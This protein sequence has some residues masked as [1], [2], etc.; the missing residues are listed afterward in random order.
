MLQLEGCIVLNEHIQHNTVFAQSGL[1]YATG[2][3]LGPPQSST[4]AAQCFE[5]C[6]GHFWVPAL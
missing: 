5:K 3:A 4:G 6:Y 2:V 1:L